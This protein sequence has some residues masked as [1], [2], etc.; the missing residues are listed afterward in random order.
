MNK[1]KLREVRQSLW[2]LAAIIA[3][4]AVSFLL[5]ANDDKHFIVHALPVIHSDGTTS[6]SPFS[7][8]YTADGENT[9]LLVTIAYRASPN[10]GAEP[11]AVTFQ[12][13]AL[14][15]ACKAGINE[16]RTEI[17]YLVGATGSGNISVTWSGSV[18]DK[19]YAAETFTGVNQTTPT[20]NSGECY[21]AFS[22]A[23]N[24]GIESAPGDLMFA[25]V[26][27]YTENNAL[28]PISGV[29]D[30]WNGAAQ[31]AQ[32]TNLINAAGIKPGGNGFPAIGWNSTSSWPWAFAGLSLIP[33]VEGEPPQVEPGPSATYNNQ[34]QIT[35]KVLAVVYYGGHSEGSDYDY[36]ALITSLEGKLEEGTA[37]H[38]YSSPSE[39]NFAD[40]QVTTTV[41]N[42]PPPQKGTDCAQYLDEVN[43]GDWTTEEWMST[44]C[45]GSG[46]ADYLQ[47]LDENNAC[48][49]INANEIDEVWLF[50]FGNGGF[51]EALMTGPGAY[52]TNA[53][54][55]D[56]SDCN[57]PTHIMGF[58]YQRYADG[59][60]HSFAHRVEGVMRR[61]LPTEFTARFDT[62]N[63]RMSLQ[64]ATVYPAPDHPV[65]CGNSHWA[66][67]STSHYN[68]DNTTDIQSDCEDWNPQNS[69][70]RKAIN[71]NDWGCNEEGFMVWWMQNMPGRDSAMN[72][73]T[74]VTGDRMPNWW[75]YILKNQA[76]ITDTVAPTGGN[77]IIN[78]G[79]E[80]TTVRDVNLDINQATDNMTADPDMQMRISEGDSCTGPWVPVATTATFQV[81]AGTGSKNVRLQFRDLAGST[82]SCLAQTI[83][84]D[85]GTTPPPPPP[86]PVLTD[87]YRFWSDSYLNHFYT[88]SEGE[89]N[90]VI[91]DY[92]DNVWRYEFPAYKASE[93]PATGLSPVYRFW[94]DT[95]LSH[96]YTASPS[97]RDEVIANY[98]N[99]VW[100]YEGIGFYVRTS[101]GSGSTPIYR[102][103][104]DAYQAHFYTASEVEKDYVIANYPDNVWRFESIAFYAFPE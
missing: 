42:N 7:W 3:V 81:S 43:A 65:S 97:E 30:L 5:F 32:T 67:N 18:S 86:S 80:S 21:T 50:A 55:L 49:M 103:W 85:A 9:F 87:V 82:T 6:S 100:R 96:F 94:S 33:A 61:F 19:V 78:D 47:M 104:S 24:I 63:Y 8:S 69:G 45:W 29:T 1:R 83:F 59:A 74:K 35:Q 26:S 22:N 2:L 84:Y 76:V 64:Y 95:Y 101:A 88:I 38:K 70:T 12:G 10:A 37:Y 51:W 92:P 60:L 77:F 46:T 79:E 36:N 31:N 71:C 72:G 16:Y 4:T 102:F 27:M 39:Q 58:S 34:S 20:R 99:N 91:N 44:N 17:W 53:L 66:P 68:Y 14:T 56:G 28:V 62:L 40:F 57:R 75:W 73:M 25:S 41:H 98:P 11:S 54:V 23:P 13:Q 90:Q 15:R 93:A 52:Y 89:R 48:D